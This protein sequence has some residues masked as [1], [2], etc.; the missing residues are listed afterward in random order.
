MEKISIL[1]P[2]YNAEKY[3]EKCI[4]SIINQT[5]KNIE[6]VLIDDESKDDSLKIMRKMQKQDERIKIV[7]IENKGVADA[8]NKALENATGTFVT[9]VDS[10]DT[11]EKDYLE[12]LYNNLKKYDADIAVINCKNII[13]ET[14][15]ILHKDFGIKQIKEY[16]STEAVKDLFYYNFLRHSPWGKLYKK[17]V[18]DNLKFPLGKNYEDLAII[19]KTFLNA[20]KIIYIPE[21]KYNYLIRK[22]SIVHNEIRITD[23]Q[24]IIEYCKMILEDINKNYP[25]LRK[26]AEFLLVD[27]E[28]YLWYRIPSKEEYLEY[29][30]IAKVN[31]K[32]YRKNVLKDKNVSKKHKVAIILS[33]FGRRIYKKAIEI[34]KKRNRI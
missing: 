21:E 29:L 1:V 16:T 34:N 25:N 27:H 23:V 14:G 13:E 33:Y 3:I 9:F 28:L 18:W 20:N 7:S 12:I 24:A 10:D 26:A 32:K 6:I 2:V 17:N 30:N 4:K 19:Y 8:R 31:V 5:Y 15:A 22:G 11:I